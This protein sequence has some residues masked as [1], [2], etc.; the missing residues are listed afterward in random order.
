MH[1]FEWAVNSGKAFMILYVFHLHK[2]YT[3]MDGNKWS[4]GDNALWGILIWS[5]YLHF[6]N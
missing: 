6:Q 4:Q 3:N 5:V 2:L 1:I